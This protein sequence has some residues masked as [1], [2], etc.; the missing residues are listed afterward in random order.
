MKTRLIKAGTK[1]ILKKDLKEV[2]DVLR[3]GGVIVYPTETVYGI[4]CDAENR[5][6]VL[7]IRHIKG[8]EDDKPMLVLIPDKNYLYKISGKLTESADLLINAFWPGPLTLIINT[9]PVFPRELTGASSGL[10]MRVSS[11]KTAMQIVNEFGGYLVSTS[12]NRSGQA[13]AVTGKD[14]YGI[15]SGEADIIIDAGACR[16]RVQ[17][18]VVDT[19][20]NP[21][22]IVRNGAVFHQ[23]IDK[24]LRGQLIK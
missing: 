20:V 23:D 8:R 13:P 11:N 15:F 19:R 16:G 1:G 6:A 17:S 2:A 22:E 3:S 21:P 7:R 9:G 18:T 10:G 5:E 14:A 12:A 24:A 4:G